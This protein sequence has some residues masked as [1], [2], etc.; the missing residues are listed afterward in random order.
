MDDF[1]DHSYDLIEDPSARIRAAVMSAKAFLRRS[2]IDNFPSMEISA[3]ARHNI[4]W[5]KQGFKEFYWNHYVS[6]ILAIFSP[7]GSIL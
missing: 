5:A 7:R 4:M 6:P 2:L 1:I 3:H